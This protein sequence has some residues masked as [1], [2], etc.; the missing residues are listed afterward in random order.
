MLLRPWLELHLETGDVPGLEW[1]DRSR[2]MFRILW[3]H[4][5][6]GNWTSLHGAV[7]VEWAKNTGRYSDNMDSRPNYAHLKTRL[8]CAINKAPDIEEVE[9]LTNM[10]A[11]EPFKVY[12][13]LPKPG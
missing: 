6:K 12:K 9:S 3:K 13:F 11:Y 10:R 7:F 5:S 2:S 1:V 8:R 4:R